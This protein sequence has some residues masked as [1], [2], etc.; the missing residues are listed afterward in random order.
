VG[1][2]AVAA[3]WAG[4]GCSAPLPAWR[5]GDMD[6]PPMR[7]APVRSPWEPLLAPRGPM[8]M[9]LPSVPPLLLDPCFPAVFCCRGSRPVVLLPRLLP[10][11]HREF[12]AA[13]AGELERL[14][15]CSGVGRGGGAA[16]TASRRSNAPTMRLNE[17][18]AS[19]LRARQYCATDL[20][21]GNV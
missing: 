12:A 9:P 5:P 17:G 13:E 4:A 7:A 16:R 20:R 1:L 11:T 8:V 19:A 6:L 15:R 14:G 3:S 10:A 18:R 21:A 2:S